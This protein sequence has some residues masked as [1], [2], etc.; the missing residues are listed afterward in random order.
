MKET[1][2]KG[3]N[4]YKHWEKQREKKWL[5]VFLHGSIYWG[6]PV[7]IS[8]FIL[9]SHFEIENMSISKLIISSVLFMIGGLWFGLSQFIRIDNIYI[10][11]NDEDEIRKGIQTLESGDN[12]NYENLKISKAHDETLNIQNQLIWFEEKDLTAEK[13]DECFKLVLGDFLR[14]KKNKEFE[15]F[16]KSRKVRFQIIDNSEKENLLLEKLI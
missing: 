8:T 7:A 13:I 5:Y 1:N 2:N 12:W 6:L 11:L 9:S 3:E 15:H 10:G 4:F 16:I 14:L